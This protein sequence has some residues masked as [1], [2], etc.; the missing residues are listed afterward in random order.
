[1]YPDQFD[2]VFRD[3]TQQAAQ[4]TLVK[5]RSRSKLHQ[6]GSTA[7]TPTQG[8]NTSPSS[9]DQS[10]PD[11]TAGLAVEGL[12][13]FVLDR[14]LH[15]WVLQDGLEDGFS[16]QASIVAM[17]QVQRNNPESALAAAFSAFALVNYAKRC[18]APDFLSQSREYSIKAMNGMRKILV[19]PNLCCSDETL[20]ISYALG[21]FEVRWIV[22][23]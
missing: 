19:D 23:Q 5:W 21:W 1:V 9:Q 2:S 7:S 3:Q 22:S 11:P 20:A 14:F 17:Y 16:Y 8:S 15:D 13:E 6:S 12:P 10:S 4:R 18:N